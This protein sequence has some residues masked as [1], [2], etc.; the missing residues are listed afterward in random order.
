MK[1]SGGNKLNYDRLVIEVDIP[2]LDNSVQKQI[3]SAIE[4]KLVASPEI[5]GEPLRGKLSGY[6]K[7]RVGDWRIV[8]SIG[9][10]EVFILG[11]RHRSKIYEVIQK[12]V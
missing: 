7:L 12:R 1:K 10:N 6:W 5:Y 4:K 2:L 9:S 11:I 8:Y 3:S